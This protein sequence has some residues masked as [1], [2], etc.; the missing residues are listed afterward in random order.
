MSFSDLL[1]EYFY[2]EVCSHLKSGV[3]SLFL[4]LNT[5]LLPNESIFCAFSRLCWLASKMTV[6]F[7]SGM[8]RNI[9]KLLQYQGTRMS[10]H[11]N[12]Y[13]VPDFIHLGFHARPYLEEN[14]IMFSFKYWLLT[15]TIGK[16]HVF[17]KRK[18]YN[19]GQL[20]Y[21]MFF[22]SKDLTIL[23]VYLS[24]FCSFMKQ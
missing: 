15:Q 18:P 8:Q 22:D 2:I 14:M 12:W 17:I 24:N 7:R 19:V 9:A 4:I 20:S 5:Q 21:D 11:S 1:S 10:S 6:F 23:L 16:S 13:Q 3:F